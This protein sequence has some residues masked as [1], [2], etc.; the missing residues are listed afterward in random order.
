MKIGIPVKCQNGHAAVWVVQLKGLDVVHIGVPA[1]MQC[2]CP[3][4][5]IGEGYFATGK[6][7]V[8]EEGKDA[9]DFVPIVI[10]HSIQR[11]EYLVEGCAYGVFA[12]R[13]ACTAEKALAEWRKA[14][15]YWGEVKV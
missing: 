8:L 15:N 2:A 3:K 5:D 12:K 9:V 13:G 14:T 4:G 1:A 10:T 6:H 11:M 7:F